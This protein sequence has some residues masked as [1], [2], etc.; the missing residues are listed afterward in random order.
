MSSAKATVADATMK[1]APAERARIPMSVPLARL[2]VNEIPGYH[3]H[4]F[5]G[6][7]QRISRALQ[8]GYEFVTPDEVQVANRTIGGDT[9]H[10]GNSDMGTRVSLPTGDEVGSD[11][12]PVR[13]YL[14]KI[15]EELW[16]ADQQALVGDNS[17][18]EGVRR[19]LL[20]GMIGSETFSGDDRSKVYVDTKR[21][22][23]PDFLKPKSR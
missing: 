19:A 7:P 16:L 20:G 23:I 14:M 13:L 5:N 1:P 11:G 15:K 4:W 3:L 12:Q 22:R 21:T 10:D 8:G 6:N 2:A 9:V 18:L 17:R